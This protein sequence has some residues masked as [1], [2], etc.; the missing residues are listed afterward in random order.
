MLLVVVLAGAA[1]ISATLGALAGKSVPHA[2]ALGYYL[3]GVVSLVISFALGSRGPTRVERT[4]DTEDFRPSPFGLI[5]G[6]PRAGRVR[7]RRK[8]TPEERRQA[9]LSSAGL[10][11]F[12]LLL[13]LLGAA[14]DP[15]RRVF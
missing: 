14:L 4:E 12:G 3:A 10:F 15:G 7:Q 6:S 2:L 11:V 5:F 13:I 9:R 1:A 8:V